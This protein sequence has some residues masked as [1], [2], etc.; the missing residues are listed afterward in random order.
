[1]LNQNSDAEAQDLTNLIFTKAVPDDMKNPLDDII[2]VCIK[3]Q[4]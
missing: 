4:P 2:V 1:M 3:R